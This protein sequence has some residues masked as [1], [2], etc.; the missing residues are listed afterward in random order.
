MAVTLE[1]IT[2]RVQA[3]SERDMDRQ[4]EN[5]QKVKGYQDLDFK[6][7][8]WGDPDYFLVSFEAAGFQLEKTKT[9]CENAVNRARKVKSNDDCQCYEDDFRRS[10]KRLDDHARS[11]PMGFYVAG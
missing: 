6:R 8:W 1:S 3:I 10:M 4:S 7:G 5:L 9:A 2:L 11:M